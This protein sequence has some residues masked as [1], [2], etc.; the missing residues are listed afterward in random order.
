MQ[1]RSVLVVLPV[2]LVIS[3]LI[4]QPALPHPRQD[5][6]SVQTRN[7][8]TIA[9]KISDVST[10][11]PLVQANVALKVSP[12]GT[13][14]DFE[15]SFHFTPTQLLPFTIVSSHLGYKSQQVE[16]TAAPASGLDVALQPDPLEMGAIVV[17]GTLQPAGS[18][19]FSD[20]SLCYS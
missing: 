4:V 8:V 7:T 20:S 3:A 15:G 19:E 10:R 1:H 13:T 16:I 6:A 18:F 5:Q 17:T 11:T 2:S 12:L 14:S 9:G